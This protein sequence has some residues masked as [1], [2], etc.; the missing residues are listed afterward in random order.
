MSRFT[1]AKSEEARLDSIAGSAGFG[2]LDENDPRS[3]TRFMKK[4]G[5]EFGDELGEDFD[6]ALDE[7]M[8]EGEAEDSPEAAGGEE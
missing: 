1:T 2:D 4:M 3:V 8:T 7:A 5:S 6:A